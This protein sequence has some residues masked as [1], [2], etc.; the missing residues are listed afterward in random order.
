MIVRTLRDEARRREIGERL[1][2]LTETDRPLWG[3]MDA[4]QMVAHLAAW[5][6]MALGDLHIPP[7]RL[8]VRH[9]PLKQLLLYV[10]PFPRGLPTAPELQ[11]PSAGWDADMALVRDGLARLAAQDAA[12]SWPDHPAFG[13]MSG[14]QWGVLGYR[15]TDHHLRQFGV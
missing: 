9:F 8:I 12:V 15:H 11:R 13:A 10:I 3:R 14:S 1:A 6:R 2:R 5:F 4:P 7:R